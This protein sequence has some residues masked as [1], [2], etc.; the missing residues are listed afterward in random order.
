M[1]CAVELMEKEEDMVDEQTEGGGSEVWEAR[2]G[3]C[4]THAEEHAPAALGG[5][6]PPP[7]PPPPSKWVVLD[8]M[9]FPF[10]TL[11]K[12]VG[13]CERDLR[14]LLICRITQWISGARLG[15]TAEAGLR[16]PCPLPP[17]PPPPP[18][19]LPPPSPFVKEK[20]GGGDKGEE[21]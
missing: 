15:C 1:A 8:P 17:P 4:S 16:I 19:P 14:T 18:P 12:R 2:K 11:N 5:R 21:A 6:H 20:E 9:V 13:G 7:P 10:L 3:S